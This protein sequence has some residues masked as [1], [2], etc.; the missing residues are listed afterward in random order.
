[1]EKLATSTR[2][3]SDARFSNAH[4]VTVSKRLKAFKCTTSEHDNVACNIV[5]SMIAEDLI[6]YSA[7]M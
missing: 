5:V 7:T 3:M 4:M 2:K 1:M 6:V